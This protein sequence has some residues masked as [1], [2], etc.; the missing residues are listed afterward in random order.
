MSPE[1]ATQLRLRLHNGCLLARSFAEAG[2]SAVFDDIIMG[3]RLDDLLAEMR[4]ER[5]YFVMLMP[6][7]DA[8]IE[9]E[10]GRGSRQYEQWAWM[11]DEVRTGTRRIGLRLDTTLQTA[12]ETVDELL[13]RVWSEGLVEDTTLAQPEA[14]TPVHPALPASAHPEA[15]EG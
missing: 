15:L 6:S 12:D 2:F 8:V 9:R 13:R 14:P 11:D 4:G 5:F 1:A 3:S 10:H 7:L